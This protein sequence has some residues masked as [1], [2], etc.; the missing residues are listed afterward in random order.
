MDKPAIILIVDDD[1]YFVEMMRAVLES[2]DYTTDA[3]HYKAEALEKIASLK[4]DLILLDV[5]M[6]RLTDGFDICYQ[7]KHDSELKKIP[8][9]VVS[10]ITE[11]TGFRFS[12]ETDGEYFAADDYMEKPVK[13]PDLLERIEKLLN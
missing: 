9:L 7:L 6:E 8:V 12:P 13:A 5:M 2:K 1:R 10:A 3:A 11:K 4:P